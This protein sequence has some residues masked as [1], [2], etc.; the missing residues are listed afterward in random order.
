MCAPQLCAD[1]FPTNFMGMLCST[2]KQFLGL[3]SASLM[4]VSALLV[5]VRSLIVLASALLV[6]AKV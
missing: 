2:K 6:L 1:D 5:L 3:A 4:L